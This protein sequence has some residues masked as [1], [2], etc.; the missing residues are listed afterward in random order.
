MGED[1]TSSYEFISHWINF[2][3]SYF[4]IKY[5]KVL[6]AAKY[7]EEKLTD[8]NILFN[9]KIGLICGTGLSRG[10]NKKAFHKPYFHLQASCLYL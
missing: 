1:T 9:P 8:Q 6:E 2:E 5:E 4:R 7:V 3:T 10:E